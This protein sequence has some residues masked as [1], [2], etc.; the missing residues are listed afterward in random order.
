MTSLN[1]S[2]VGV[3]RAEAAG[4]AAWSRDCRRGEDF[5]TLLA[6]AQSTLAADVLPCRCVNGSC[7][8]C[9]AARVVSEWEAP[10]TD[11]ASD[12]WPADIVDLVD[13]GVPF[14]PA[15]EAEIPF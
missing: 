14:V 12:D 5:A 4:R 1:E 8:R 3:N 2:S 10:A 13:D 6:W 9:E 7:L 15:P 11:G